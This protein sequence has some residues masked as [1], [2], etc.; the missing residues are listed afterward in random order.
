MTTF[1]FRCPRTGFNVQGFTAGDNDE[2]DE[3]LAITCIAC[4]RVHLVNQ[5]TGKVV[6][7][8]DD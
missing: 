2:P 3:A 4:Q 7:E 8:D 5:T 6:G 1:V